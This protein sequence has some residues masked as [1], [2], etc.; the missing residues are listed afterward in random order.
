MACPR[1]TVKKSNLPKVIANLGCY[2]ATAILGL[3]PV[4]DTQNG[5]DKLLILPKLLSMPNQAYRGQ[6]VTL[7]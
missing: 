4:I 1:F 2:P 7:R 5:A 6:G 3:K